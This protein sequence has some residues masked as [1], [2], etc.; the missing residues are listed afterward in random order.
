MTVREGGV[1]TTG[2]TNS[3]TTTGGDDVTLEE[4]HLD[5][6]RTSDNIVT[7]GEQP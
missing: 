4:H 7:D 5:T 3:L 6:D 2:D 1:V